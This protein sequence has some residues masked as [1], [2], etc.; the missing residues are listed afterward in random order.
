MRI[1]IQRDRYGSLNKDAGQTQLVHLPLLPVAN[2]ELSLSCQSWSSV[3]D[4]VS[5]VVITIA[6]ISKGLPKLLN[7]R[8]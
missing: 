6:V 5:G 3:D 7:E 4:T 8:V 2:G 1:H